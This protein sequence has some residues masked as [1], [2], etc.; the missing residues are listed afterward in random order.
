MGREEGG[1]EG[2]N[3]L[4]TAITAAAAICDAYSDYSVHIGELPRTL[5]YNDSGIHDIRTKLT[6][7]TPCG[8][9]SSK[10]PF[11]VDVPTQNI[12][13]VSLCGQSLHVG[14]IADCELTDIYFQYV[15]IIIS[16]RSTE[17]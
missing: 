7:S 2:E 9:P 4:E 1:K 10:V 3:R 16:Q 6:S 11:S 12:V 13:R 5:S 15:Q 8:D 14:S 17:N